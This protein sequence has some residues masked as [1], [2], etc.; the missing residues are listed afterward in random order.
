MSKTQEQHVLSFWQRSPPLALL[1]AAQIAE[2]SVEGRPEPKFTKDSVPVLQ[3]AS[4][5]YKTWTAAYIFRFASST[6]AS[7]TCCEFC[8]EELEGGAAILRYVARTADSEGALYGFD[9]LSAV[10]VMPKAC[11]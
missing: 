4:C 1:A 6:L 7:S 9:A 10:Q 11:A 2:V 8:R 5:R 3:L